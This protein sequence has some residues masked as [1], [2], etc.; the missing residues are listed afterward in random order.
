MKKPEVISIG[1]ILVE[2]MRPAAGQPLDK[3]GEFRGPFA[4]GAPAIF[5][6]A[7]SRL[8][9]STGFIGAVG[10]DAFGRL[11]EKRLQEENVDT[12]QMQVPVGYS[13]GVAFVAYTKDG[14]REFVFHIRHA[15]AG[16]LEAQSIDPGYFANVHWLHISGSSLSL[17]S[18][19][20]A[21]C[22][23]AL[24]LTKA[25][26]GKVSFDP[27]LR[28]E[29]MPF[30]IARREFTPFIQEADLL[31]P[32]TSE[33]IEL[34]GVDNLNRAA[35]LLMGN[36]RCILAVKRGREGCIIFSDGKRT[37]IPGFKVNEVDPTGAGD[38]F[39]AACL[40]GVDSG[41]NMERIGR[42]ATAAGALA[43]TKMG[44]MEGA[45]SWQDVEKLVSGM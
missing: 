1:E 26:G 15:A 8:G 29:L 13:T 5:S 21:A 42:F 45:P 40:A 43:V 27:N 9:L 16:A 14:S 25:A 30:E 20:M 4:S 37:D 2:I 12:S 18:K 6:V 10:K 36:R 19:S 44:P 7:A 17:N 38:C 34:T 35:E 24:E 23:R 3:E 32:T 11:L 31:L 33:M 28:P 22:W 41:W 39:N